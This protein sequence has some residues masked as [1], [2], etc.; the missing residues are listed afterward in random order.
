MVNMV[1]VG[2]FY[3]IRERSYKA[4]IYHDKNIR[5]ITYH[6]IT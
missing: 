6:G 3:Q 2:Y 5:T 4:T 1:M